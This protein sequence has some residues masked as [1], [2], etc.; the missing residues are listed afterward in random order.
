MAEVKLNNVSKRWGSFVGVDNFNITIPDPEEHICLSDHVRCT[1][2]MLSLCDSWSH[3]I[4]GSANGRLP[5]GRP[6]TTTGGR[7]RGS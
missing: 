6:Q 1:S 4:S 7:G 5:D 2:C 3:Y